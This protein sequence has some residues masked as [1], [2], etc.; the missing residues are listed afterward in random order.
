MSA[1]T[2][3]GLL[4]CPMFAARYAGGECTRTERRALYVYE[5]WA[6]KPVSH[7]NVCIWIDVEMERN[8]PVS[9]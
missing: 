2:R 6:D 7:D 3:T 9:T 8:S 4:S 1:C 5:S